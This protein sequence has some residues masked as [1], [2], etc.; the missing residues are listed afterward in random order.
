VIPGETG[1]YSGSFPAGLVRADWNNV[2]PRI[3]AAWRATNR[4]VVRFGYGLNYNTGSYSSIARNLYQQPP[5]FQTGTSIGTLDDP[6]AL[7]DPFANIAPSTIT[8]SFGIDKDYE[9]GLIHQWNVDYSR[10]LFRM[11]NVGA[12]Y[13]GTRGSHLDMLR[14][15]NR[16]PDGLRLENVQSFTWQSS[17]GSSH[18]NGL[19]LRVQK[20]QSFGVSGSASYTLSRSWDNTTAT[21]GGATVAQDDRDLDAEWGLSNFDRRHQVSGNLNVELPWGRNRRWLSDETGWLAA[22]VGGWSMAA[23]VTVQSGTPLTARCSSCASDVARGVGGT[24]R[25][26]YTGADV[27]VPDPTID[28]FFNTAAFA[29]PEAGTFGSSSRNMI[30]GPGSRQLNAQFTRDVALGG[31]RNVSIN[32]NANNLLN[33]VNYGSIDTNVNSPTFGQVLSVRG[34]RTVRLNLRFR[35]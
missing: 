19:S 31:N 28:R 5:Y 23:T 34:R 9:L 35:F 20:R 16:G 6:L 14:A 22:V 4:S 30:I 32:V 8:N 15:P 13:I 3:G 12:T 10:D 26:D 33:L 29:I 11:W 24:L 27:G 21:G 17:E 25:A 18:M 2:A 1:P 7:T